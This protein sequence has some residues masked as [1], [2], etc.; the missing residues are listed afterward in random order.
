MMDETKNK[1]SRDAD[2]LAAMAADM[3]N[4]LDSTTLFWRLGPTMP[5]MTLGGYLMREH[6]LLG[7]KGLLTGYEQEVVETAVYNFN[8]AL[9]ER[10]V[11]F[12]KK[13][14]Q[15]VG[16]RLRQWEATIKDYQLK[17]VAVNYETAVEARLMI[18]LL[19]EKLSLPPYQLPAKQAQKVQALDAVLADLWA[20]GEFIWPAEWA[21]IYP[22]KTFWWLYGEPEA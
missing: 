10:I 7:L 2:V 18:H 13:A 16:A 8:A 6:R 20:K 21:K 19:L 1:L 5:Q 22:T 15:A 9:A 17:Q 3:G 4:Y 14:E 12:E 11:R